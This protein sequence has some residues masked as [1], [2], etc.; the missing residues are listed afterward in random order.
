MIFLLTFVVVFMAI[1]IIFAED[2]AAVKERDPAAKNPLEV[3]L[4]YPGLHA[5]VAYRI[6]HKLWQW[7]IPLIPRWI[8]QTAK[9]LTGIE[10]HP[11]AQIGRKF[12]V[13]H[14]MGV[15]I[16]ETAI[17]KDN[18]L[19]YQGVTLGGTGKETGKRHPTVGNNVVVGA[20]AKI[21]GNITIGDNSYI[22]AN[23]VVIKNVPPNSTIVGIPGRITKQE[24]QKIDSQ[25]DH[26]HV[27]DPVM[28][29]MARLLKRIKILEEKTGHTSHNG[30]DY[31][32]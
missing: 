10:I 20:G 11:G 1:Y 21:L 29:N 7:N 24:G 16:G 3:L 17:I 25:L 31:I 12:F 9:F 18:V 6:A 22:G 32:I 30:E 14:G 2:I 19:L 5:L 4:L 15:V 27:N 28:E 13:D 26:T 23:A 8:S